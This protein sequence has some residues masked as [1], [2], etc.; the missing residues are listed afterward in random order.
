MKLFNWFKKK[1]R[2][3]FPTPESLAAGVLR[4]V[5][6]SERAHD[7]FA[8]G[9]VDIPNSLLVTEAER[10]R[11]RSWCKKEY[12]DNALARNLARN[13]ALGVYGTG[14][15]LQ[16]LAEDP[17]SAKC[18]SL[19]KQWRKSVELDW[20]IHIALESLFYDGEAFFHLHEDPKIPGSLNVELIEARR[21]QEP[22][23]GSWLENQLEGI[24]YNQFGNPVWYHALKE[25]I[26]PNHGH[27]LEYDILPADTVCH[28]YF[29]DVVNQR[30]GLPL[31]QS[32]L[33]M[34]A[35]LQRIT[36]ASLNA[37]ELAAKMNLV[38]QTGMDAAD[39]IQCVPRNYDADEGQTKVEAFKTIPVPEGGGM[40]FLATGMSMNQVR[41]EHPNS[42]F[43]E[44]VHTFQKIAGLA[45]GL[46]ENLSTGSS[47]NYNFSSAQL[48]YQL[49]ARFGGTAQ[50][51][52]E[53][54]LNRILF[55]A[56]CSLEDHAPEVTALLDRF[57]TPESLPA[58]WFFPNMLHSIDRSQNAASDVQLL[59]AGLLT[60]REYCKRYGIDYEAHM[61]DWREERKEQSTQTS[62]SF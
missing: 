38:I 46:P 58:E 8:G 49:F 51:K 22:Y 28:L 33:G 60:H 44:H 43:G 47:A 21:I 37:W 19:W 15:E 41:N 2:A 31:L 25:S 23:G 42:Q 57:P 4:S 48:D 9:N 10:A 30:R 24:G 50:K 13:F 39:F 62:K 16:I 61:R 40:T 7:H 26:D 32:A 27:A 18:E 34:L 52:I 3:N 56:L 5:R 53:A 55:A 20:K 11:L 45:G 17:I 14:P 6:G 1:T 35:S 29:E 12:L 59:Q 54:I 36:D